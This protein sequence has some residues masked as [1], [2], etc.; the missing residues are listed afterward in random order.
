[1][2]GVRILPVFVLLV[3][4]CLAEPAKEPP[5]LGQLPTAVTT[6]EP[7]WTPFR[8]LAG[9]AVTADPRERHFGELR[10]LT[11]DGSVVA[12][13]WSPDGHRLLILGAA[14]GS[15]CTRLRMLDVRT[16]QSEL[17]PPTRGWVGSA[18]FARGGKPAAMVSFAADPQQG[19]PPFE[20]TLR[21]QRFFLPQSDVYSLD[22]TARDLEPLITGDAFEGG[23][24]VNPAGTRLVF[25]ST[26]NGDAELYVARVDGTD[27]VRITDAPGYDGGAVFSPDGTKLA[28]HAERP[29]AADLG[30]YRERLAAGVVE[31]GRLGLMLAGADGQHPLV[32]LDDGLLNMSPTFFPD[33]RR[34]LFAANRDAGRQNDDPSFDLYSIDPDGPPTLEGHPAL[35][36]VTYDHGFDAAPSWS[37][38]GKLVAFVSSRFAPKPGQTNLFVA[39]W[40]D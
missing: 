34:I 36:R 33:S 17:L 32:L 6:A 31:P 38:D 8:V 1:M 24:T 35:E 11:S 15:P 4:A 22:L 28:W 7:E 39:R 26:R 37:P 12:A 23:V 29:T 18:V 27:L 16:G 10:Q 14:P 3:A 13:A 21:A 25:T 19:C 40:A 9:E 5:P 20:H 2:Q 30:T